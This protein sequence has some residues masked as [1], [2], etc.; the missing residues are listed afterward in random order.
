MS[1]SA[2]E[3]RAAE[4]RRQL[5]HHNE[6]YYRQDEPEIGDDEYDALLDELRSIEAEFP[7]LRSADSPTQRVGAAP[8]SRFPEV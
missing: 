2:A 1:Q 4:L 7:A 3:K 5:A 6:L 8:S